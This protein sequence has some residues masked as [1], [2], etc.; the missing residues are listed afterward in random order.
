MYKHIYIERG[1]IGCEM[2][3]KKK[4]NEDD[5]EDLYASISLR[6]LHYQ[7]VVKRFDD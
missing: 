1:N 5:D 4:E 3:K 6:F 2:K 7:I